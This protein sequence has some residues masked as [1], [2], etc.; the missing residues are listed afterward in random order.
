MGRFILGDCMDMRTGMPSFPN[1]HFD[2]AIVDPPYGIGENWRKDTRSRFYSHSS[3]YKNDKVPGSEY[4]KELFR[5]SKNQI[6]WGGNY[7]TRY[8][9][10]RNSW[11]VWDKVADY[12]TQHKSEGELAWTSFNIPLRIVKVLWNGCCV[13]EPRFGAH[14]HEKPT[15]LYR[16]LVENYAKPGDKLLDTHVGSASS[17]IAFE[18]LGFD[19]TGFEIDPDYYEAS[20]ARMKAGIQLVLQ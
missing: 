4:F 2:L 6:I 7:Y 17:L 11:I 8:L 18:S 9:P 16:W 3:S 10:E 5:V 13:H 12:P 14:P 1:K 19:Y 20:T 15:A